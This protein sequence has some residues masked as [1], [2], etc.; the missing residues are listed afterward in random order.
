MQWQVEDVMTREVITVGADAPVGHVAALLDRHGISA[1]PV[2]AAGGTVLGV[3][4]QADLLTRVTDGDRGRRRATRAGDLMTVRPVCIGAEASLVHAARTM[5]T[6]RVRRLLVTDG[7]DRLLGVVSRSDLLRPYARNDA[8]IGLEA[9]ELL[10]R[11]LWIDPEQIR[12][13]MDDGTA[14]L[15]GRVGRRS[16]AGI[17]TRLVAAV[18]GVAHVVDRIGYEFDDADLVRS[19]ANRTH[20][21]SAEPFGPGRSRRRRALLRPEA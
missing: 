16:T 20:P 9:E 7:H 2:T 1:V 17:A 8:E 19:R 13:R 15:T 18:P 4:S 14:E 12:V 11:R 10:R 21:F 6:H 5:H 3:V